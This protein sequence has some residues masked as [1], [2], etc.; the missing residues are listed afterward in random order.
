MTDLD[1]L[2]PRHA[3]F[4][5][6]LQ[7]RRSAFLGL[8]LFLASEVM[9]FGGLFMGIIVYRVTETEAMRTASRHLDMLIGGGNTAVLLTSSMTMALAVIAARSGNRDRS[10]RFLAATAGLGLAFLGIKAYEYLSE[11]HEGLMPQI[12]PA[13][14]LEPQSTELFF[15]FYFVATGLHALHLSIGIGVVT[16]LAI[17]VA[18]GRVPLPG[19]RVQV[20]CTGLYWHF[21]DIVWVFLYPVLYLAGRS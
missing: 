14:P 10:L 8:W 2:A 5:T 15:N 16:A 12:G 1:A 4:A 20:E 9:M 21:V 3:H 18:A 11:F 17:R 6:A 19:R 7:E 13:F